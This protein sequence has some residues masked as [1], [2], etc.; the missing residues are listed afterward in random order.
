MA[1]TAAPLIARVLPP[2][3]SPARQPRGEG[4]PDIAGLFA[5]LLAGTQPVQPNATQAPGGALNRR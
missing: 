4:S 5:L 3:T 1:M 2:G